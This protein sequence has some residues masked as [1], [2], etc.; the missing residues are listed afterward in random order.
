MNKILLC[1]F[2]ISFLLFSDLKAQTESN[3]EALDLNNRQIHLTVKNFLEHSELPELK[4]YIDSEF[5]KSGEENFFDSGFVKPFLYLGDGIIGL[6]LSDNFHPTAFPRTVSDFTRAY[7][8]R[9][10]E[11]EP[12]LQERRTIRG[13]WY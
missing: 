11:A 6:K 4:F 7:E 1:L 12:T 8:N 10:F 13:F 2:I 9:L 3:I 5:A